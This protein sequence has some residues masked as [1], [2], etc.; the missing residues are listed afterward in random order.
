MKSKCLKTRLNTRGAVTLQIVIISAVLALA[1]AGVGIIVYN[2]NKEKTGDLAATSELIGNFN[3]AQG[4]LLSG[5]ATVGDGAPADNGENTDGETSGPRRPGTGTPLKKLSLSE[6]H[7]C[8]ITGGAV[9]CWGRNNGGNLGREAATR[10]S[11]PTPVSVP[12]LTSN[13]QSVAVGESFSCA[14]TG[15][16]VQCWGRNSSGQLGNG[17][18]DDSTIPVQVMGITTGATSVVAGINHACAIVTNGTVRCWGENNRGQLGKGDRASVQDN[19]PV[20]VLEPAGTLLRNIVSITAGRSHTCALL[21]NG[22]AKCW[23]L[24]IN[25]RLANGNTNPFSLTPAAVLESPGT[26]LANIVQIAA[27]QNHTCAVLEGGTVKCWGENNNGKLGN[28]ARAN[29]QATPVTVGGIED[30][31]SIAAGYDHT[32]AVIMGGTAKCWGENSSGQL[33]NGTRSNSQSTPVTVLESA[34]GQP[35]P[36]IVQISAGQ[37]HTCALLEGE[38]IK[39]WGENSSGQLGNGNINSSLT[40]VTVL[41]SETAADRTR[42]MFGGSQISVSKNHTCAIR[43]TRKEVWCWGSNFRGKLGNGP[44]SS[45]SFPVQASGVT[46]A[47]SITVG[48]E[49]SCFIKDN[50]VVR[51]WGQG[52]NGQLGNGRTRNSTTPVQVSEIRTAISIAAGQNHTCVILEG[53]TAKCWGFN[54]SGQ[55]GDGT[56][57]QRAAPVTVLESAGSTTPLGNIVSIAAGQRHTCALLEDKTAKCWGANNTSQLGD[58][59]M[60]AR[61]APVTVLESASGQP[62]PNIVQISAGQRHTCAL[63]ENGTA[64]CW[65]FNASGQLGNGN[66]S[67]QTAPVTVLESASGQ[68]LPNIVQITAGQNHTCAVLADNTAK[69]WGLNTN[70]QLSDGTTTQRLLPTR[71]L[72]SVSAQPL[73]NIVQITAGSDYTCAV[74]ADNTAK[75]WGL[76]AQGQLGDGTTDDSPTPVTV[77]ASAGTPLGEIGI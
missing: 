70:G 66:K 20:L 1:A 7:A 60:D 25:G 72:G 47:T 29:T 44:T 3:V 36:N 41:A 61:T 30:A 6:N 15:R 8:A 23:G 18:D 59:T 28:G 42:R 76:N 27:G 50:G 46:S 71:L 2:T 77:L 10:T 54:A 75:C 26:P 21:E 22:T 14:L 11:T 69:C 55:L 74:L 9:K 45:T 33:G 40:P 19:I 53:G 17:T 4:A 5:D 32:C 43:G 62:L 49:Y 39:C 38:T 67:T 57:I 63:L 73:P 34:S 35:L 31:I 52:T 12:E 48:G 68:P 58:G 64:K 16:V 37:R 56:N 24:N 13:T 51:C 65:G